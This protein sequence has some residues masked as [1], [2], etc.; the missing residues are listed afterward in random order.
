MVPLTS[1]V[2]TRTVMWI[3]YLCHPSNPRVFLVKHMLAFSRLHAQYRPASAPSLPRQ[4]SQLPLARS[5]TLLLDL[6]LVD[7]ARYGVVNL[8]NSPLSSPGQF[9]P[10]G[11]SAD[12]ERVDWNRERS[13]PG[14]A[15]GRG[16]QVV[17]GEGD[18]SQNS[19]VSFKGPVIYPRFFLSHFGPYRLLL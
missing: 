5:S 16:R 7:H 15:R 12:L 19:C 6:F 10:C 9:I 17:V 1:R 13:W 2:Q 11:P 14:L 18:G 8:L 4:P 3:I